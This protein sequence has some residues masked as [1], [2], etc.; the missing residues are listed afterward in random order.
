M[1]WSEVTRAADPREVLAPRAW[2]AFA[3]FQ[4]AAWQAG[5]TELL[6]LA[7][8]RVGQLLR[9]PDVE[10]SPPPGGSRVGADRSASVSSWATSSLFDDRERAA[11]TFTEQFVIDVA[12]VT[13]DH[14]AA[15]AGAL[16]ETEL[17]PFVMG[18]FTADYGLRASVAVGRLFTE[19]GTAARGSSPLPPPP[20]A[21]DV[22]GSELSQRFDAMLR[23]IALLDALDP[24]TTELVRLRGAR[25]HNCRICQST[26]SVAAIRS[27]ADEGTFDKV[28]RYEQSDLAPSVVTALRLTDKVLT[29]PGEIDAELAVQV[30][31]AYSPEQTME[32]VLDVLRNSSQKVAVSLAGD[33]PNV[34]EGFDYYDVDARGDVVFGQP[35]PAGVAGA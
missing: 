21:G 33:A 32:L 22:D 4:D 8:L 29:Q 6:E 10:L 18:L 34:T 17:G 13:D 1:E 19:R 15:L 3:A 30:R 27:G 35:V 16:A 24:V 14:R 7:R 20:L 26:R 12:G 28:D 2:G 5:P 25:T 23:T 9:C 11:L 31:S